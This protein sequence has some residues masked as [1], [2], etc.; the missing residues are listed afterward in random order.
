MHTEPMPTLD[1]AEEE[2]AVVGGTVRAARAVAVSNV[3]EAEALGCVDVETQDP[4]VAAKLKRL[5]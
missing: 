4:R 3:M 5:K 1:L 2:Q